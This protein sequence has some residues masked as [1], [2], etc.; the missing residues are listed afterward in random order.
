MKASSFTLRRIASAL[1]D[2]ARR[3]FADAGV[4][5]STIQPTNPK[6]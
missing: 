5:L 4:T 2:E 6:Q 1:P 3:A